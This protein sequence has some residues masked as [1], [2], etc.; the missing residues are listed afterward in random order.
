MKKN[1]L[2][3]KIRLLLFSL[4]VMSGMIVLGGGLSSTFADGERPAPFALVELF[5]SEGC[6]SCPSA[7]LF[8]SNLTTEVRQK[9]IPIY[10]LSFHVDYWNHLGWK[11][12]FSQEVFSD[13]QRQYARIQ[14]TDSIYTPQMIVNGTYAF[15]GQR[16][17]LAKQAIDKVMSK[18]PK[19]TINFEILDQSDQNAIKLSY[20]IKGVPKETL[21]HIAIVERGLDTHITAGENAGQTLSQDNV[22]R[23]FR[24]F[25]INKLQGKVNLEIPKLI[26]RKNASVI[27]YL[28]DPYSM[29]VLG[30]AQFDL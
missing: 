11:D 6:S 22:V 29:G 30:A 17:D 16:G 21:L 26:V 12:P 8:F 1:L 3:G 13:R 2:Y 18:P 7:D 28:Q 14:N 25:R 19:A 4:F 15:S 23:N 24:T 9:N 20:S 5:T 27:G 10:T